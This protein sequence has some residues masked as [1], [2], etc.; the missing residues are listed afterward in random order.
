MKYVYMNIILLIIPFCLVRGQFD[1]IDVKIS[2]VVYSIDSSKF[3]I[4]YLEL[5]NYT[6]DDIV[7]WIENR[8]VKD[9]TAKQQ[10]KSYFYKLKGDFNLAQIANENLK[11]EIL[12]TLYFTFV[13]KILPNKSFTINVFFKD[14]ITDEKLNIA[15]S[16]LKENVVFLKS[17]EMTNSIDLSSLEDIYY[18]GNSLTILYE[19]LPR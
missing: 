11:T 8:N 19:N 10:I 13:K 4:A 18:K 15:Y 17:S 3:N 14:K 7:V 9:L 5:N 1:K 12:P 2:N 6:K 16:F